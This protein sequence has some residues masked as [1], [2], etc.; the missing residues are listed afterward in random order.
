VLGAAG[1]ASC[2]C[3]LSLATSFDPM[4]PVP[5]ITTI[6]T[7]NSFHPSPGTARPLLRRAASVTRTGQPADLWRWNRR[8]GC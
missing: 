6:F 1:T 4:S 8:P 7:T 2:P 3:S 5:P